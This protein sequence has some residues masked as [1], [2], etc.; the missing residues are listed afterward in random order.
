MSKVWYS[1]G[2][3]GCCSGPP[4]AGITGGPLVQGGRAT[5]GGKLEVFQ[6]GNE[7]V[8]IVPDPQLRQ[9]F[10]ILDNTAELESPNSPSGW[11]WGAEVSVDGLI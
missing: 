3:G 9:I 6:D 1:R 4:V 11:G 8:V 5:F 2:S 10:V 7:A